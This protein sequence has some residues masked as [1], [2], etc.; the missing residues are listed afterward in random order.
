MPLKEYT[1]SMPAF[2]SLAPLRSTQK[3]LETKI[4]AMEHTS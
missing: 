1:K 3:D 4:A 2:R